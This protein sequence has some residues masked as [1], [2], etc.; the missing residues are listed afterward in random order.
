MQLTVSKANVDLEDGTVIITGYDI[1][2]IIS[3]LG[4]TQILDQM[5][6]ATVADYVTERLAEDE[7]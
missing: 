7:E 3:E 1:S 2:E 4:A 6:F 5:D